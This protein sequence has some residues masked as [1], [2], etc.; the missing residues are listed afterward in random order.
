MPG[1]FFYSG[2][3]GGGKSNNWNNFSHLLNAW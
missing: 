1:N 2:D 3:G